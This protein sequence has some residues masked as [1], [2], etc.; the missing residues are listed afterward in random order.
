MV[1]LETIKDAA[2]SVPYCQETEA[3]EHVM[4]GGKGG[5]H[6]FL[7]RAGAREACALLALD[8]EWKRRSQK[9]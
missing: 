2:C 4:A 7:V 9:F 5:F 3:L 6:W 8:A 1:V